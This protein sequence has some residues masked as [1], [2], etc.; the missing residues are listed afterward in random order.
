MATTDAPGR[1]RPIQRG[2]DASSSD[3]GDKLIFYRNKGLALSYDGCHLRQ[4]ELM[5]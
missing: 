3:S 2:V 5:L 4:P 1:Y